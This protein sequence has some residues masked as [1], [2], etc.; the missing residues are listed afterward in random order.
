V[1]N[2]TPLD[3]ERV[4]RLA[5]QVEA[6]EQKP[7]LLTDNVSTARID[8]E[9]TDANDNSPIFQPTNLYSFVVKATAGAGTVIGQVS[10]RLFSSREA[11]FFFKFM[12]AVQCFVIMELTVRNIHGDCGTTD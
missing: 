1:T 7:N 8:I 5:L 6:V 4:S 3:R 11:F 9:L 10:N 12:H 2:S